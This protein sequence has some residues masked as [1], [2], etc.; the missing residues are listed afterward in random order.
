M[1]LQQKNKIIIIKKPLKYQE[2]LDLMVEEKKLILEGISQGKIFLLQKEALYTS[3]LTSYE[4]N[5]LNYGNS[6]AGIPLI[7]SD[8]GGKITYHGPG[9]RVIYFVLKLVAIVGSLDL[10]AFIEKLEAIV[11]N[12]LEFFGVKAQ[13]DRNYPG[14]WIKNGKKL[15][16]IAALGLKV[17]R[18]ITSHGLA[19]NINN[20]LEPFN[21]I[22]PC[23][24]DF[25][26]RGITSLSKVLGETI[27][28][29]EFDKVLI[30]SI[31]KILT[32]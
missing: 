28:L 7:A 5:F 13:G 22:K 21:F 15:E 24:I 32:F 17:S 25:S 20:S 1:I 23:G 18:G 27:S 9:Q 30:K 8:R 12:S 14:V 29:Q 19:I 4:E 16:K 11:I 6:I 26:E 10:R 31:K 2:A 3:G